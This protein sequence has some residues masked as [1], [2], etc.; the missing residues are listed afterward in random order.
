MTERPGDQLA[1]AAHNQ[2][3]TEEPARVRIGLHTAQLDQ[4]M[5]S[6]FGK[7]VILASRIADQAQGGEIL[8]PSLLK[9]RTESASTSGSGKKGK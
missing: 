9:E 3:H 7:I 2:E 5:E 4:E 1:F 6:F 8:V